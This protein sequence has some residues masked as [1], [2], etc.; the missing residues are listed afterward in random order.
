MNPLARLGIILLV[1]L[2]ASARPLGAEE[3]PTVPAPDATDRPFSDF[4]RGTWA[5]HT[6]AGYFNELGPFDQ[7]MGFLAAGA[8]Y[9][10]VDNMSL[11]LELSG[12]G[13]SQPGPEAFAGALGI[14]FRH[15]LVT[16]RD[17]SF[18]VDLTGSM[19]EASERVP[20]EGTRFNFITQFGMGVTRP[21]SGNTDLLLGVRY[22]HL[23]NANI[24]GDDR[25]PSL[26]GIAA[27]AGLLIRM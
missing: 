21:L 3:A 22:T 8:N 14:V 2:A 7:E 16:T 6:Y 18:F 9:Y 24:E 25:N 26:N 17:G 13:V 5:V 19:W 4:A 1:G 10:F 27:Y 23:S 15:H 12:Y 20:Q 11:G